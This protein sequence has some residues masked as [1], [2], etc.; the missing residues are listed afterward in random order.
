[1]PFSTNYQPILPLLSNARMSSYKA[2]FRPASD[3]EL[4]GIYLWSQHAAGSLYPL[5]QTLEVTVRNAID[6]AARKRFGDYWWDC[7][8]CNKNIQQTKFYRNIERGKEKLRIEWERRERA[9]LKLGRN[10]QI[11]SPVPTWTHDQIVAATD[12]STWQFVLNGDFSG[13]LDQNGN[14]YLWPKELGKS[15]KNFNLIDPKPDRA[16]KKLMDLIEEIRMYR[17]R[18]FHHEPIWTKSAGGT[19]AVS[20][21]N[22][23]RAKINKISLLLEV[24]DRRKL[25]LLA[26]S[27]VIDNAKRVCSLQEL[28]MYSIHNTGREFTKK[29]RRLLRKVTSKAS[30]STASVTWRHNGELFA[31]YKVR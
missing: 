4:Y 14:S 8:P 12:F 25:D 3:A 30:K 18:I 16:R 17:N 22:S 19:N 23:V 1:M 20:A 28:G 24:V 15:F 11:P 2:V 21:I 5:V 26:S 27:G 13:S 29:Q 6:L 31:V 9:R 10:Q 7:I